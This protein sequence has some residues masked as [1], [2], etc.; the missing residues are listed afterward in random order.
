MEFSNLYLLLKAAAENYTNA[1]VIFYLPGEVG[2][3][4][5]EVCELRE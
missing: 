3:I 1:G 4:G 2:A 5:K